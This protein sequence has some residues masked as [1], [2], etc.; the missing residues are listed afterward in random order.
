MKKEIG[1]TSYKETAFGIIPRAILIPLEIEGTKRAWD[2]VI[3]Q[4]NKNKT[5]ITP[6]FIQEV[7]K[8][9]FGWIFPTMGG[10]FRKIDVTVSKHIPPKYYLIPQLMT[11]FTKDV[12][13]RINHLS[14]ID[15]PKFINELTALLAWA[16]HRF[17]WIH[18]FQDYNG[19]IGRLLNNII[20][21]HQNLP[22]I[23]LKV[24]T[25]SG[26]KKYVEALQKAD[27][28]DYNNLEK[29]IR[30]AIEESIKEIQK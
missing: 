19:R 14:K 2:F 8:I 30:S 25:T 29:L 18:P 28:G 10:K 26:R 3:D 12:K 15:N 13:T 5:N 27:S 24:E 23:E 20:L 1:E 4:F 22:P 16:H 17:L 11:D 21:L 7:H 6:A 9:G